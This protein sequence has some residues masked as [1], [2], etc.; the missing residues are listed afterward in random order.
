MYGS[1]ILDWPLPRREKVALQLALLKKIASGALNIYTFCNRFCYAN[2]YLDANINKFIQQVFLPFHRDF[3]RTLQAATPRREEQPVDISDTPN[4][5][6]EERLD[7]LRHLSRP[8]FDFSRLIRL[9]EELNSSYRHHNYHSVALLTRAILDHVPPLFS[10][11]TFVEVANNYS[12]TRSFKDAM[13]H[14]Q[15]SARKIADGHLHTPIRSS[16]VLPNANQ[17]NFSNN[18]D[19]LLSEIIRILK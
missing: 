4:L 15:N 7:Q 13:D 16:E 8:S 11:K 9:C 1:G 2:N 12:G 19:V 14:L 17:V 5:I 18:L 3:I 10:C 6:D